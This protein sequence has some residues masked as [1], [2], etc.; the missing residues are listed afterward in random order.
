MDE[1]MEQRLLHH[2]PTEL[3]IDRS[4]LAPP[5]KVSEGGQHVYAAIH[6]KFQDSTRKI[7]HVDFSCDAFILSLQ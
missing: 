1:N 7:P 4:M 5:S 3:A 2:A 6:S